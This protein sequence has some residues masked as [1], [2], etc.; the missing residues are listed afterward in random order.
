MRWAV[1]ESKEDAAVEST[2]CDFPEKRKPRI[3]RGFHCSWVF[4]F[5]PEGRFLL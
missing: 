2:I 4:C 3:N 5:A 1:K